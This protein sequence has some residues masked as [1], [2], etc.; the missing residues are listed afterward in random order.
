[1]CE[2][3][4]ACV[5]VKT[6]FEF[7]IKMLI[8]HEENLKYVNRTEDVYSHTCSSMHTFDTIYIPIMLYAHNINKQ[9]CALTELGWLVKF[10]Y[11]TCCLQH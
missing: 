4:C 11:V 10:L 7:S 8:A 1:M 6:L 3:V 9:R 5:F 2:L